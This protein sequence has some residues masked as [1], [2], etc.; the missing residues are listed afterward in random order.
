MPRQQ[1]RAAAPSRSAPARPT[2]APQPRPAMAPPQNRQATTLARPG[3][4]SGPPATTGAGAQ[5]SP[6]LFGQMASTAAYVFVPTTFCTNSVLY[7][8]VLTRY[9]L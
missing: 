8:N 2:V 5:Q 6:G 3:Q 7:N 4:Q 9:T 1:R